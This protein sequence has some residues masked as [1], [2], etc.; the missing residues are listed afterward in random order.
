MRKYVRFSLYFLIFSLMVFLFLWGYYSPRSLNAMGEDTFDRLLE[1][2]SFYPWYFEYRTFETYAGS[3]KLVLGVHPGY[4]NSSK[5]VQGSPYLCTLVI[6]KV[7][8]NISLPI[9]TSFTIKIIG[10]TCNDRYF[11]IGYPSDYWWNMGDHI[12]LRIYLTKCGVPPENYTLPLTI[13]F[14]VYALLPLG[15]LPIGTIEHEIY[16]KVT[17]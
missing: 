9:V 14:E 17:K 8:E 4:I 7:S 16:L 5:L 1:I 2:D 13:K 10:I 11:S 15:Y 12:L 3:L 6:G